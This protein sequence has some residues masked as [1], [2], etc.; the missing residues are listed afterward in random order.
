MV[1]TYLLIRGEG[2]GE[3]G[4]EEEQEANF[5]DFSRGDEEFVTGDDTPLLMVRRVC[6]TP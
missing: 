6:F 2:M 3:Q 1:R 4:E 5:D